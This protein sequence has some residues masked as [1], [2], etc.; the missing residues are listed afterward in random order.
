MLGRKLAAL[1]VVALGVVGS[2]LL[3]RVVFGELGPV[4]ESSERMIRQVSVMGVALL[5]LTVQYLVANWVFSRRT[6]GGSLFVWI[7]KS[8]E[9][10]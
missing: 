3:V 5:G 4:E 1:G 9:D 2:G 6:S 8:F 7:K 10:A